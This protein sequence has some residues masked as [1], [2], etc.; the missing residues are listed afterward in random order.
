MSDELHWAGLANVRLR[1]RE[2][3]P[4]F[5]RARALLTDDEPVDISGSLVPG[6]GMGGLAPGSAAELLLPRGLIGR[7]RLMQNRGGIIP[8]EGALPWPDWRAIFRRSTDPMPQTKVARRPGFVELTAGNVV[9]AE[10]WTTSA[11]AGL[12]AG[13]RVLLDYRQVTE[14]RAPLELFLTAAREIEALG[15]KVAIVGSGLLV[16]GL[17]REASQQAKIE[18]SDRVRMFEDYDEARFWLLE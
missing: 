5:L 8:W 4:C 15:L 12:S 16:L 13:D 14:I 7:A 10:N 1:G 3:V 6:G 9:S 2:V 18:R 17:R 11:E